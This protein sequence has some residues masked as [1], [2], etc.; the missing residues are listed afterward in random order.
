MKHTEPAGQPNSATLRGQCAKALV[1]IVDKQHTIDWLLQNRPEWLES[2]LATELIYG[3]TRYYFSLST[4]IESHLEKPL[5]KKDRDVFCLMIVGAYQL[6]KLNVPEHAAI[7]ETVAA[8][9]ALRK[10]WA[11]GLINAVLRKV[12]RQ[13]NDDIETHANLDHPS[14]LVQRLKAQYPGDWQQILD[15]NNQRAPM[16][17]RVNTRIRSLAEY[18]QALNTVDIAFSEQHAQLFAATIIPSADGSQEQANIE[19]ID[20]EKPAGQLAGIVLQQAVVAK[21]LPGWAK[22]HVSVQDFGAQLAGCISTWAISQSKASPTTSVLDACCAPGGKLFHLVEHAQSTAS[23]STNAP[24]W[25]FLGLEKSADRAQHA[26]DESERLLSIKGLDPEAV[27][28]KSST[29]IELEIRVADATQQDW[30]TGDSFSHI[31]I[32]APCSGT[33][34]LRRHPDIKLLLKESSIVEH[35]ATQLL[36]LKN[37]W[38]MLKAGG[39]LLYSTCSLLE[40]E[41]DQVIEKFLEHLRSGASTP[42]TT[43]IVAQQQAAELNPEN[44][45]APNLFTNVDNV[46]V[47]FTL[48]VGKPTRF[49][50]QLTPMQTITDGFYYALL[51]KG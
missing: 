24:T 1:Q 46:C 10:P 36:L 19:G 14:W 22:G 34:T 15:A 8:C 6:L 28:Q 21:S 38:P 45:Q 43:D 35:Q 4:C 40:E 3:C 12:Q 37:L 42:E 20:L 44:K 25:N 48:N 13:Q 29:G 27:S 11:R 17:L 9:K 23:N 30:W 47:K 41:N 49:G 32:D 7:N 2:P 39:T 33:G 50:W 31:C 51:Q 5:R 18:Q 16:C 26:K